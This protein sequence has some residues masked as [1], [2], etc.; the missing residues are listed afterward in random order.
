MATQLTCLRPILPLA[1]LI[2][3]FALALSQLL[4]TKPP[5][6]LQA[7]CKDQF[8]WTKSTTNVPISS[9]SVVAKHLLSRDEQALPPHLRALVQPSDTLPLQPMRDALNKHRL[10]GIRDMCEQHECAVNE[11]DPEFG[12]TPLHLAA[13]AHDDALAQFLTERGAVPQFDSVGRKPANLSFD[14]FITNARAAKP[15]HED[16]D[17]PIVDYAQDASRAR[18][19]T[20]RLVSE[21]EPFLLRHAYKQYDRSGQA[22]DWSADEWVDQFADVQVKVGAV[23]YSQYF[24][25]S[26][27]DMSL[28]DYYDRFVRD[29]EADNVYVFNKDRAIGAPGY[30]TLVRLVEDAFP[31]GDLMVHPDKTGN[32]DGIHFFFGRANSGAPFHV[33]AD[34]INGVVSGRKKWYVYTPARTV[35]SRKT[36]QAWVDEDLPLLSEDERPLECVQRAGDVVYVPLDWGHAVLNLDENT[37]G[38]ALELLNRRDTLAHITRHI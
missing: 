28:R 19:E 4:P 33:H 34:A 1:V 2:A 27:Q 35:Y 38:Y 23:P 14:H 6:L 37:F 24:N 21:G 17:F 22:S 8:A 13:F 32:V 31:M 15:Q 36:I 30:D 25:L 26:S 3:V 16:C 20:A 10:Q 29:T 7:L 9:V 11:A 12:L 5:T 18:S